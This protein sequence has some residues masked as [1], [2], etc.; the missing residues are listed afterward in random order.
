MTKIVHRSF[1]ARRIF[2]LVTCFKIP[3][4]GALSL[5]SY[6]LHSAACSRTIGLILSQKEPYFCG[7]ERSSG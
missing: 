7:P 6:F 4:L 3:L 2:T 1:I 5:G